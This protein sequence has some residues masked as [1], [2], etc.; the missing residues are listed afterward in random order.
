MAIALTALA[1][2]VVALAAG[3]LL[4]GGPLARARAELNKV[5]VEGGALTATHSALVNTHEQRLAELDRVRTAHESELRAHA[6][7]QNKLAGLDATQAERDRAHKEQMEQ[8]RTEF[9]AMA[10]RALNAAQTRFAEQAGEAL[11]HHRTEA[12]SGLDANKAALSE[13]IAPMRETLGKYEA[14]LRAVEEARNEA[15]GGLRAQIAE[16]AAGQGRVQAEAARLVTALRSSGKTSGA[17]GELQLKNVLE[18][19]GLQRGTDFVLQAHESGEDGGSKRP[20]AVVSL[21]GGGTLIID[22]KCSLNDYMTAVETGD[23]TERQAALGRHAD[24]VR[25]HVRQLASKAYWKDKG[26]AVEIVA[27]FMPG[28][29]LLGAALDHDPAL[30]GWAYDQRVLVTGPTNLIGLLTNVAMVRRQEKLA[31]TAEEI[32]RVAG[33]LHDA[34]AVTA[35]HVAKLGGDLGKAVES[36]NAVVGSLESSVLPKTRRLPGMGVKAKKDTIRELG[37]VDTAVRALAAPELL[38]TSPLP[39]LAAE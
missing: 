17:W 39:L 10:A 13:L 14:G 7:A 29:N 11:K 32:G 16:V 35:E 3:W 30:L 36:F 26:S 18:K 31:E 24:C 21:P 25:T 34:L 6:E 33:Q 37:T 12:A 2:L 38:P 28:D 27:L 9:E 19:A 20:D 5:L 22:S 1:G 23:E 15:Y 4:W 8:L